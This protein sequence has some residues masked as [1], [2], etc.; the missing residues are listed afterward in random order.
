VSSAS[1]E[2]S[3][4]T[5][6][7]LAAL[8]ESDEED[9]DEGTAKLRGDSHSS[10]RPN[11][12]IVSDWRGSISPNRL[13]N[14]FD[15]WL[16]SSPPTSPNAPNNRSGTIFSPDNRKNVSEPRLVEHQT[17]NGLKKY[18]IPDTSDESE[19][20]GFDEADFEEMLV[21]PLYFQTRHDS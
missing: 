15:G 20:E 1:F 8:Q 21:R 7:R 13:S 14:L 9:E 3:Q 18:Q 12:T 11:A 4:S 17:G 19:S 16:N 5:I 10:S 6:R 2:P